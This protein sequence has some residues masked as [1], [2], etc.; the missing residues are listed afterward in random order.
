MPVHQRCKYYKR[1]TFIHVIRYRYVIRCCMSSICQVY[2]SATTHLSDARRYPAYHMSTKTKTK[3]RVYVFIS[4]GIL[5][6]WKC[7]ASG[8][9]INTTYMMY[10]NTRI[11]CTLIRCTYLCWIS[12]FTHY[13]F[14]SFFNVF[15]RWNIIQEMCICLI[16][17]LCSHVVYIKYITFYVTLHIKG[18]NHMCTL[19]NTCYV[20][21][22]INI[23]LRLCTYDTHICT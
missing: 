14:F 23:V 22:I 3:I 4:Y 9:L 10:T 19:R 13:C 6:K 8:V 2:C 16:C 5:Y 17:T 11:L 12:Y 1:Y 18:N 21:N 20:H 7:P 15:Y